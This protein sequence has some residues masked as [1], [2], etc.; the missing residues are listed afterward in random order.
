MKFLFFTVI[1]IAFFI[2]VSAQNNKLIFETTEQYFI[3][4]Q[5]QNSKSDQCFL[6][7]G[8]TSA[9][10][11]GTNNGLVLENL[12]PAKIYYVRAYIEIEG[13]KHY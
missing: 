9:F 5:W 10:E 13:V 6:E 2:S 1:L 7:Y 11:L 4:F 3:K 12:S 8:Q